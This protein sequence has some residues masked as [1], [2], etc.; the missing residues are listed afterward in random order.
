MGTLPYAWSGVD[1]QGNIRAGSGVV[2]TQDTAARKVIGMSAPSNLWA[3]RLAE[4]GPTGVKARRIFANLTAAG[5]D[6][7]SLISQAKAAGMLPVLSYKVPSVATLN[8]GG[9]DSWLTALNGYLA[10]LAVEV[11]AT[12]WHEPNNDM[13]GAE[14]RAGSQRFLD[15][16]TAPN[17]KVGPI[18]NGWLLDNQTALFASFTSPE[19]LAAWDFVAVDSYQAGT[20]AAPDPSKPPG[21]AIPKL[22]AWLAGQGFPDKPIGLGEYNGHT[23]VAMVDAGETILSCPNLWFALAWNSTAGTYSPLVGDRLAA[24][25]ATKADPRALQ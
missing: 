10:G 6:Q 15:R 13:T 9:Y 23:G 8:A 3:T 18:L 14:F 21:R 1:G 12:F 7:A 25:Q 16:L 19:L 17:V 22:E 2:E 24:Y 11:T 4:V 5:N 20:P